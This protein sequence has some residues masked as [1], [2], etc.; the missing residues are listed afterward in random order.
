MREACPSRSCIIIAA[1]GYVS[2]SITLRYLGDGR[3]GLIHCIQLMEHFDF[4]QLCCQYFLRC[5]VWYCLT[6]DRLRGR[7]DLHRSYDRSLEDENLSCAARLASVSTS[8]FSIKLT[9]LDILC[10]DR[11]NTLRV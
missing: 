4:V 1:C 7:E 10:S 6:A 8:S 9:W 11:S 5:M 3:E 2:L